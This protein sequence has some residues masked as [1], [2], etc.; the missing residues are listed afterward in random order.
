MGTDSSRCFFVAI[1]VL[2]LL[3]YVI[4]TDLSYSTNE[5]FLRKEFSNFG[6]IA[7]VK[8]V[9]DVST[10]KSKGY[11]FIQYTDHDDAMQALESMDHQVLNGRMIFVDLAKPGREAFGGYPR[12]SGPPQKQNLVKQE[13]T[14]E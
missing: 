9:T 11:A 7:E 13:E 1:H 4:N 14:I 2:L 8:V 12:T 10:K 3:I 5:N 6:Q